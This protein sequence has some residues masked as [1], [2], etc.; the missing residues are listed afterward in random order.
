MAAV[1][2][3]LALLARL[4]LA[5]VAALTLTGAAE[6]PEAAPDA[7]LA[8]DLPTVSLT[9][10][11]AADPLPEVEAYLNG[12]R[13][14]TA[15]FV[16]EAPDGAVTR[17]TLSLARPGRLRFEYADDTPLLI[18]A[19]GKILTFI[20]YDV[21]QVTRWP[22]G[23]TPLAPLVAETIDFS[24]DVTVVGSGPGA[25]ANLVSVTA[26]DPSRPGQGDLTLIFER[27]AGDRG[28]VLRAWRV[29]DAQ[30]FVT[31]VSLSNVQ[32]GAALESDLWT[33]D[34]PRGL[35]AKR[36]RPRR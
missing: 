8:D 5:A 27:L 2:S 35:P 30:G 20:D 4:G 14:L 3:L 19:D 1:G 36:R 21:G 33:F 15:D 25:L 17:G 29:L 24:R 32:T 18:V 7:P 12:I 9:G 34:D 31:T 10:Q 26:R 28:L 13:T 23:D 16:Q 11:P 6:V 22:I